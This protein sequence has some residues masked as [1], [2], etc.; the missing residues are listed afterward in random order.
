MRLQDP[1]AAGSALTSRLERFGPP[2]ALFVGTAGFFLLSM[3]Q[4]I[5]VPATFGMSL[6]QTLF[7]AG[8]LVWLGAWLTGNARPVS[9]RAVVVAVS[10]YVFASFLS[11][12]AAT[13]RGVLVVNAPTS[14]IHS[15]AEH[16]LAADSSGQWP[17]GM[18]SGTAETVLW[19][20]AAADPES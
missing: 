20:D 15:A 3:R 13:A 5:T 2:G 18:V 1:V 17:A 11:Y 6:A 9:D 4:A 19:V 16:A 12:G 10:G 7:A 8:A 14:N